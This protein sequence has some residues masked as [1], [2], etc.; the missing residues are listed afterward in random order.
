MKVM[1][2]MMKFI[3]NQAIA[4]RILAFAAIGFFAAG[5]TVHA[6][7]NIINGKAYGDC[8]GTQINKGIKGHLTVRSSISESGIIAGATILKGGQLHLSGISNGD[9]EVHKGALLRLTGTV[10]GTVNNLD[11]NV[12]VEGT[13]NHLHT[14]GGKVIIGGSVKYAS[15]KGCISYKKG[16]VVNEMPVNEATCKTGKQ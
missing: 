14:I 1:G 5:T 12:E 3:V 13:L 16:A 7:C 11:G 10:N 4:R 15:G 6:A 8:A 2:K 9:I